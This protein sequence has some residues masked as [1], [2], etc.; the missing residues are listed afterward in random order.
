MRSDEVLELLTELFTLN[1][2]PDH[3]RSD[4]GPEFTAKAIKELLPR[5]GVK[6]IVS[7]PVRQI[8]L[9]FTLT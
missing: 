4:N 2:V 9:C 3:I 7:P 1:G 8:L 5:V 6:R